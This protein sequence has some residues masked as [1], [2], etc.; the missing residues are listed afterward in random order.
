MLKAVFASAA[1]KAY[2]L[3]LGDWTA[4]IFSCDFR[5]HSAKAKKHVVITCENFFPIFDMIFNPPSNLNSQL[6]KKLHAI[7]PEIKVCL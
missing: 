3:M 7:Y 6:Q 4:I 2:V 5:H 1:N